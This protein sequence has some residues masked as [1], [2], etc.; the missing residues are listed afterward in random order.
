[1]AERHCRQ[2]PP[3]VGVLSLLWQLMLKPLGMTICQAAEHIKCIDF[4]ML[5]C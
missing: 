5:T 1:M 4:Y 3:R 2:L